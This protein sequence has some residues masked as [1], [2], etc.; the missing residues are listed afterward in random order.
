MGRRTW[1]D[2]SAWLE[3]L[4]L[5]PPG[6]TETVVQAPGVH[7]RLLLRD[8]VRSASRP[9]L[10]QLKAAGLQLTM[11]TGDRPESAR[12]VAESLG[13]DEVAAGLSPEEKVARVQGWARAGERVAMIGDGV[14]D[15]PSLAAAYVGVAMGMRGADAALEQADV[16]LTQDRLERFY[17]A[18]RL[19]RE[20]RLIIRQNLV[21]SLG[22]VLL[23]VTG[24]L[25]GAVPL[26][27][28]VVGHEG[29][30]VVVVMNSLRLLWSKAGRE[31]AGDA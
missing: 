19:S 5:P 10:Q 25:F 17:S 15:A 12:R 14:N 16:V 30:T 11:L 22:S 2:P 26:T 1:F 20:A 21:I 9:L 3:A 8:E 27:L 6:H 31:E 28:G 29:S 7:G 18:Y 13:L 24:A 23:L 4:P